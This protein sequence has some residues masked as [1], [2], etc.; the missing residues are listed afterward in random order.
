MSV[1][2]DRGP[3]SEAVADKEGDF[4]TTF[5]TATF[6]SGQHAVQAFCGP[7]LNAALDIVLVSEVGTAG[8]TVTMILL[9][10]LTVVWLQG[11]WLASR[12]AK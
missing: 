12:S 2:V 10:L 11:G 8:P 9:L 1:T 6:D 5:S 7:I 3:V 4:K